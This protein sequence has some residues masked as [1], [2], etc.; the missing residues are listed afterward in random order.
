MYF[1]EWFEDLHFD[2]T[3]VFY[4]V[5]YIIILGRSEEFLELDAFFGSNLSTFA[6][7]LEGIFDLSCEIFFPII[8]SSFSEERYRRFFF[9]FEFD[10]CFGNFREVRLDPM[11]EIIGGEEDTMRDP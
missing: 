5:K 7:N 2:P 11:F 10:R 3:P 1:L 8:S 9:I 4:E 6:D